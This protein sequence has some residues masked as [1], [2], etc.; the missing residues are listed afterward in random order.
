MTNHIYS[1]VVIKGTVGQLKDIIRRATVA[2]SEEDLIDFN[3]LFPMPEALNNTV[4]PVRIV[5]EEEYAQARNKQ[6]ELLAKNARA[7]TSGLPLTREMYDS[8]VQKYGC[9]DWY[10]WANKNWGTKWG[11]YDVE[12][13]QAESIQYKLDND[14]EDQMMEISF[15]FKTAWS[16]ANGLWMNIS[17]Q[18]PECSF[19]VAFCEELWSFCGRTSY[20]NGEV[21]EHSEVDCGSPKGLQIASEVGYEIEQDDE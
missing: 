20:V 17:G 13:E 3:L 10:T 15:S 19:E 6:A 5:T 14:P 1:R 18:Y 21:T 2:D 8:I 9:A 4:S 16:P 7:V 11:T 12:F